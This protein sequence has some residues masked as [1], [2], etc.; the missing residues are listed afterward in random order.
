MF[1]S[2]NKNTFGDIV[3]TIYNLPL[4]DKLELKILLENNIAEVKR[5]EFKKNGKKQ[6]HWRNPGNWNFQIISMR[7]FCRYRNS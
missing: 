3:D 7:C 6:K 4:E 2:N 1:T 5:N